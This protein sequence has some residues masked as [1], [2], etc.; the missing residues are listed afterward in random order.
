MILWCK[1]NLKKFCQRIV[2]FFEITVSNVAH[3][4]QRLHCLKGIFYNI[5][6]TCL[7]NCSADLQSSLVLLK[8]RNKKLQSVIPSY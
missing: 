4:I 1:K 7:Q 5:P 2:K 6:P 3:E 8:L